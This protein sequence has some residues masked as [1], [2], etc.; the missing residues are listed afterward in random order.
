MRIERWVSAQC[1][2]RAPTFW[3]TRIR[4]WQGFVTSRNFLK[5]YPK[6]WILWAEK[7]LTCKVKTDWLMTFTIIA[8][9]QGPEKGKPI[10]T[11]AW[12]LA[13]SLCG[14]ILAGQTN[15]FKVI[16]TDTP[17]LFSSHCHWKW[18]NCGL[19]LVRSKS[20]SSLNCHISEITIFVLTLIRQL[21]KQ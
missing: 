5:I 6:P 3:W 12:S 10:S 4:R 1:T 2:C 16:A 13:H 17:T 21:Q 11:E 8:F 9:R 19:V 20:W 14:L 18:T 15:S 7:A